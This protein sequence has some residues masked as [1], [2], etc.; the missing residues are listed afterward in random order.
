MR[1]KIYYVLR[2]CKKMKNGLVKGL[3][4]HNGKIFVFTK[5]SP[6]APDNAPSLKQEINTEAKLA[7]FCDNF[8]KKPLEMFLDSEGRKIFA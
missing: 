5:P 8:I 7:E 6:N 4:T 1:S 2:Q 3:T